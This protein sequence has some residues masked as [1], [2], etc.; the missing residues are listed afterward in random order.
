MLLRLAA[1]TSK[2]GDGEIREEN[3]IFKLLRRKRTR[4][5]SDKQLIRKNMR[6]SGAFPPLQPVAV[7]ESNL[8]CAEG[9]EAEAEERRARNKRTW[10]ACK[11][12]L[13]REKEIYKFRHDDDLTRGDE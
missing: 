6:A 10:G 1:T 12:A 3:N 2:M 7:R 11:R 9:V 5:T 8:R 4:K 13:G